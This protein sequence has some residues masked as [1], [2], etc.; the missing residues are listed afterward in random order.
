MNAADLGRQEFGYV[1]GDVTI[2]FLTT[3][4]E[5]VLVSVFNY[6]IIAIR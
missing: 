1:G 6:S 5:R 2:K 4:L 3:G